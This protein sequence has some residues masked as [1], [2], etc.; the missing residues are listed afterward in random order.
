MSLSHPVHVYTPGNMEPP[1]VPVMQPLTREATLEQAWH[2]WKT[3]SIP[4][5]EK[6]LAMPHMEQG[7]WLQKHLAAHLVHRVKQS[8]REHA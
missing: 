5:L 2:R 3:L 6:E 1:D 8:K 4:E 7:H